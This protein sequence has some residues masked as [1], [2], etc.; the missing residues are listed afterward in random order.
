MLPATTRQLA[1]VYTMPDY[2]FSHP[3]LKSEK[4]QS[5]F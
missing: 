3:K 4:L 5:E 2:S 1:N